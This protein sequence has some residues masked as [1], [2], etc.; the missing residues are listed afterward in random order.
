MRFIH[1]ILFSLIILN[2]SPSYGE[3]KCATVIAR[4]S[5][6]AKAPLLLL[7]SKGIPKYSEVQEQGTMTLRS[8]L[9]NTPE[10]IDD[11]D[12]NALQDEFE[13]EF[14]KYL[15][16]ITL[17]TGV[18]GAEFMN[19]YK[20]TH[21]SPVP[22]LAR[23]LGHTT[24]SSLNEFLDQ[25]LAEIFLKFFVL[26]A[27]NNNSVASIVY[28]KTM[29]LGRYPGALMFANK[30]A[31]WVKDPKVVA[32][33]ALAVVFIPAKAILSKPY[34]FFKQNLEVWGYQRSDTLHRETLIHQT[35][36][37]IEEED[38]AIMEQTLKQI[39]G[40]G[41]TRDEVET[42]V[43]SSVEMYAE[44]MIEYRK[45]MT[46]TASWGRSMAV[47]FAMN[48]SQVKQNVITAKDRL[49]NLAEDYVRLERRQA[50]LSPERYIELMSFI[51]KEKEEANQLLIYSE[52][53]AILL[54]IGNI[55]SFET[56]LPALPSLP[57]GDVIDL[58]SILNEP[59]NIDGD[60]IWNNYIDLHRTTVE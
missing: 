58:L 40:D 24:N 17:R 18:D 8:F 42:I 35:M 3:D 6:V 50:S 16:M 55:F 56:N 29:Q 30:L 51:E 25:S 28:D 60:Q 14:R 48:T 13:R 31:K 43:R 26:E 12:T 19:A 33:V 57:E 59:S 45:S 47:T 32:F 38:L 5:R 34:E 10:T 27:K 21:S 44:L 15:G 20:K 39:Y 49:D 9:K 46:E 11:V 4:L 37:S 36:M 23:L 1:L 7:R 41:L 22:D 54:M 2:V 53:Y 52:R